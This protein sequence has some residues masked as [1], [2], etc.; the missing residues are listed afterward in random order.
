ML[1]DRPVMPVQN[2]ATDQRAGGQRDQWGT[3]REN[4]GSDS[5]NVTAP[6]SASRLITIPPTV[7]HARVD[8]GAAPS[9]RSLGCHHH[10]SACGVRR[11][12]SASVTRPRRA[13]ASDRAVHGEAAL[14]PP[15]SRRPPQQHV[16][17]ANLGCAPDGVTQ[18]GLIDRDDG[19]PGTRRDVPVKRSNLWSRTAGRTGLGPRWSPSAAGRMEGHTQPCGTYRHRPPVTTQTPPTRILAEPPIPAPT[20]AAVVGLSRPSAPDGSAPWPPARG[21]SPRRGRSAA[22]AAPGRRS[23]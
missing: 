15:S 11:C 22:P 3:T 9:G 19:P 18:P 21:S 20:L 8:T 5:S 4:S 12:P 7:I 13:A 6:T 1:A 16:E 10:R 2:G 23:R 14:I 17:I